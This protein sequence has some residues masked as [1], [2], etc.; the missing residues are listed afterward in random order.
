MAGEHGSYSPST[1]LHALWTLEGLGEIN[2]QLLLKSL[3]DDNVEIRKAALRMTEPS[4]K[5]NESEKIFSALKEMVEDKSQ[6]VLGQLMLSLSVSEGQEAKELTRKIAEQNENSELLKGIQQSIQRNDEMKR[7]GYK[8]SVLKD[9]DRRSVIE[10]AAIFRTLCATCHGPEGQGLPTNIA[11]H[12]ISKF[13]LIEQKEGI[14]KIMLHGLTGPV[15]GITYNDIMPPMGTN[16]DEWIAAV[17][18]Y[19]R[20]DLGMRSFPK[21]GEG[22]I[23]WVIVQPEQVKKIREQYAGRTKPWTWEEILASRKQ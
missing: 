7:Y 10:G 16:S 22:Y 20:Y 13:K 9:A 4:L 1:R 17:L 21:M 2:E 11:P 12:L 19:I 8:L 23:N 15:D 6:D 14:I 18:N 5:R 3:R